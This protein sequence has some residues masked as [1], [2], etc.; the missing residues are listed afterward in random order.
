MTWILLFQ[1]RWRNQWP[2]VKSIRGNRGGSCP[3]SEGASP[4]LNR[5]ERCIR[6]CI[7]ISIMWI[8]S[9]IYQI[10]IRPFFFSNFS[11]KIGVKKNQTFFS[12]FKRKSTD[13]NFGSV[14]WMQIR[15]FKPNPDRVRPDLI[16]SDLT[17]WKTEFCRPA[18][19]GFLPFSITNTLL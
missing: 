1:I 2:L 9:L 3:P 14:I 13:Y 16:W 7:S 15:M 4:P 18:I 5:K 17:C 11:V 12:N 6:K 19:F 10:R 8:R